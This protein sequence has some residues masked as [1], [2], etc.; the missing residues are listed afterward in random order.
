MR[1]NMERI[2][3][4][5]K[6]LARGFDREWKAR[7]FLAAIGV[8]AFFF[9]FSLFFVAGGFLPARFGWMSSA[10][11]L[12]SGAATLL[13]ELRSMS[14][15]AALARFLGISG[16]L[17][18]VEYAGVNTGFPFGAYTY[19]AALGLTLAG[20]PLAISVAWYSTVV[21]A[22][23]IAEYLISGLKFRGPLVTAL[24]AG[25]LT[26]GLDLALEPMAGFIQKYW[27]WESNEIP[28]QNY[29]SWFALS[30]IAVYL[31]A[32]T[33][34]GE[35]ENGEVRFRVAV[36]LFGFHFVLFLV[37]ILVHGYPLAAGIALALVLSP[38]ALLALRVRLL[39]PN[40][41]RR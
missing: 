1:G 31:L 41:V 32:R 25:M 4:W 36:F 38:F 28:V 8:L 14:L 3:A 12:L 27:V 34:R 39:R 26:L 5:S 22:W 7:G 30:V 13:A 19:T 20:V 17:F 24:L 16:I 37:T 10:I 40:P 11:I 6:D 29:L 33:G 35:E 23:R 15:R 21:N 18:I 9:P 2:T